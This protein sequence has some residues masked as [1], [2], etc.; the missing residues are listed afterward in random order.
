MLPSFK[1][2]KCEKIRILKIRW[3]DFEFVVIKIR[4]EF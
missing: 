2:Q 1:F 3:D 4:I